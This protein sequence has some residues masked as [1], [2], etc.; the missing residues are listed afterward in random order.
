MATIYKPNGKKC[1]YTSFY[2]PTSHGK[3]E[4]KTRSTGKTARKQAQHAADAI[5]KAALDVAGAGEDKGSRILAIVAQVA[6][7]ARKGVLNATSARE[8][9]AGILKISTGEDMPEYTIRTWV[10]EWLSRK[11][12]RTESTMRAYKTH[13][14]HFLRWLDKR[15]DNTLQSLTVSDM[16]HLQQWLLNGSG[17]TRAS[18]PTTAKQK[19]KTVSSIFIKAMN[20]GITNFNPVAALDPIPEVKKL[21]RKPFT[22]EE[23]DALTNAASSEEWRGIIIMG[24][25]TGLRLTDCALMEWNDV[26]LKKGVIIT[27]PRKTKRKKTVVT[28]PLHPTLAKFLKGF[29]TP[30]KQSTHVFPKLATYT[31]AGRN[32]L[33]VQFTRLMEKAGVS[34]GKSQDTGGRTIYERSFH[35]LRHTLTSWLAESNVSPEIRM[36]ILGHKSEDVHA[37]YTHIDDATLKA[38]MASVPTLKAQ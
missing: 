9:V 1:Y 19:M 34:R 16:R 3:K 13:T 23:V 14:K 37:I 18:S 27:T 4:K 38:A 25:F 32:G 31:G 17:G 30:I 2:V 12:G 10:A 28:I 8:A 35:S 11:T 24:A 15:A 5:E 29:P 20:E 6:E 26:N 33:S 36:Q 22:V 7:E 21:E